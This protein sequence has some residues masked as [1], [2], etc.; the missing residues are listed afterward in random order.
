MWEKLGETENIHLKDYV[1]YSTSTNQDLKNTEVITELDV[2]PR[3]D[4]DASPMSS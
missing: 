3:R 1:K 2:D 4:D